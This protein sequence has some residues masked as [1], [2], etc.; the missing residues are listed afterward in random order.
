MEIGNLEKI[1]IVKPSKLESCKNDFIKLLSDFC[2][3]FFPRFCV[4]CF[5]KLPQDNKI[6][7]VNCF[8]N[9]IPITEPKCG[10][11]GDILTKKRLK[12]RCPSCPEPPIYFLFAESVFFY[13]DI[14]SPVIRGI[15]YSGRRDA[16]ELCGKLMMSY[17]WE[18]LKDTKIDLIVPVPLHRIRLIRRGYNQA[19]LLAQEISKLAGIPLASKILIRTRSTIKQSLLTPEK[20][21]ENVK[22]AFAVIYPEKIAGKR[23]LL[24]DDIITTGSTANECARTLIAF[25]A[26]DVIVFTLAHA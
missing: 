8:K 11:C 21:K 25:G 16:A 1:K 18:S 26:L 14:I 5:E 24:I 9:L 22:N 19:E 12:D 23:I 2:D 7:C 3:F 4:S 15:K 13:N 17:Y 20:R 6:L 10:I